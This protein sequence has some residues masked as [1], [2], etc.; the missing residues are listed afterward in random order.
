MRPL[1]LAIFFAAMPLIAQDWLKQGVEAYKSAR[2]QEA[3]EAFQKAVELNPNDVTAHLYL[4]T[5]WMSQYIPGAESPENLGVARKAEDEF[6][7][8]LGL[9]PYN[10][11][12]LASL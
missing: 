11:V 8:V 1:T 3:V 4:A 7:L 9:E 6:N 2:Y 10:K 12:A 5:A